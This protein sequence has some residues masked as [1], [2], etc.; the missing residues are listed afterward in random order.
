[1][2]TNSV[3]LTGGISNYT[4]DYVTFTCISIPVHIQYY[5]FGTNMVTA[6]S[7]IWGIF[8]LEFPIK[9]FKNSLQNLYNGFGYNE[10]TDIPNLFLVP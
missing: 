3:E 10:F 5:S 1:M 6:N 2:L 9:F 8:F 4:I 7:R